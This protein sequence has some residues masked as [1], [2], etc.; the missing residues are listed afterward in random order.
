MRVDSIIGELTRLLDL[1]VEEIQAYQA[2]LA[3]VPAGTL[4]DELRLFEL[5]HERHALALH[6]LFLALGHAP[7]EARP[8]VKGV[9]IGA[10]TPPRARP[11]PIEV[12]EALRG[13]EQLA[14]SVHV[15]ALAKPLP[16]S[17]RDP[18]ER[19]LAD[20]RAHLDWLERTLSRQGWAGGM[21]AAS[22]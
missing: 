3:L 11:G 15:K 18:L 20:A 16:Q 4:R 7:P 6:G 1:E 19:G 13:N 14:C 9:V 22:P 8:D 21:S 17:V 5:E 10:I 12:L 2:A